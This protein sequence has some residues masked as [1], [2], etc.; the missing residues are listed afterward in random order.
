MLIFSYLLVKTYVFGT[1][2]DGSFEYQM[3][4]LLVLLENFFLKLHTLYMLISRSLSLAVG[5]RY[6]QNCSHNFR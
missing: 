4:V 1:H 6:Q 3:Y 5:H 2:Q